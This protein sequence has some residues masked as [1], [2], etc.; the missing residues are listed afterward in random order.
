[1]SHSA[2]MSIGTKKGKTLVIVCDQCNH[3]TTHEIVASV[4]LDDESPDGD[5]R[6]WTSYLTV[7]CRGCKTVSFCIE[8][9]NTEDFYEHDPDTLIVRRTIF[10]SRIAGRPRLADIYLLPPKLGRVYKETR[11]ALMQDSPVLAGIGI[12]AIVESVCN[13][14]NASGRNLFEK[15]TGL[16]SLNLITRGEAEILQRLRFMGNEAAHSVKEHTQNELNLAFDVV[17]HLLKTVYILPEQAKRLPG[18]TRTRSGEERE[19]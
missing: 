18:G 3:E 14:E 16:V 11:A 1:M 8:S 15:I 13:E 10:P 4:D 2:K 5:I 17:E 12:R 9:S 19:E 6:V 7:Q